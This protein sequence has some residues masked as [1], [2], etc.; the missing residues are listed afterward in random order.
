M[1]SFGKRNT[2]PSTFARRLRVAGRVAFRK[3]FRRDGSAHKRESA[4]AILKEPFT[5]FGTFGVHHVDFYRDDGPGLLR[6]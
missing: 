5:P 1:A 3:G 6:G 4:A 2:V